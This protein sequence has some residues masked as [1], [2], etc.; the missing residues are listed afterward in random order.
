[1]THQQ[2]TLQRQETASIPEIPPLA[3]WKEIPMVETERTLEPLVP[4]GMFSEHRN[5]LT[6]SVYANEHHNSPYG[7]GLEGSNIAVFVREGVAEKLEK[8][9]D[10]LPAGNYLMVMD[11]YRSLEVQGALYEQYENGLKAQH[12][13]WT[14]EQLSTETQKYVSVPSYDPSRP[15]PHNTGASVD[16][17]IVKVNTEVQSEIEAIDTKLDTI[18]PNNWQAAYTLEIQRSELIRRNAQMLNFATRFDYGGPEAALRYLEEKSLSNELTDDETE[19]LNNRRLLYS[20]MTSAGLAPYA[21]EWWHYNDPAS[22][23]GAKV[24][25]RDRA[26]YGAAELSEDNR[27][28]AQMRRLHHLNSVR[29]ARGEEWIPAKGLE[30]QY[31]LAKAALSDNPKNVWRMTNTVAKI[32]PPKQEDLA[33]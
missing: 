31:K 9:A 10:T 19:A 5:I 33:A 16:A 17:V 15:S 32:E 28:F 27:Q 4:L 12:P 23:M 7:G 3:G 18:D 29:L 22:Q 25:G 14:E 24:T 20:V 13:D 8:A 26:E 6:S 21:D 2:E 11:A 30:V 1:M